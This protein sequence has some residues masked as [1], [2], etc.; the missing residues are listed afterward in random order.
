MSTEVLDS[1]IEDGVARVVFRRPPVNALDVLAME[2]FIAVFAELASRDNVRAVILTG[3]GRTFCAGIDKR[4][5]EPGSAIYRD[6]ASLL[7][8]HRAFFVAI[9][10]FAK[11]VIAAVNGAAIGAGFALAGSC[12]IMVACDEAFFSMPEVLLGQPSGAAFITR[13]FGQSKAR[14]LFF[15]GDRI[16]AADMK[17]LGAIEACVPQEKLIDAAMEIAVAIARVDPAIMRSAK[18]TCLIAAEAPYSVAKSLEYSVLEQL[19]SQAPT[20]PR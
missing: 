10:E 18:Q 5:F 13:L 19:A 12:D 11:P 9:R 20:R 4:L 6:R 14:R 17:A 3:E 7:S 16:G 1:M 2:K 8:T 15:T